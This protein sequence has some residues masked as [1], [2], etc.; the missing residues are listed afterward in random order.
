MTDTMPDTPIAE[1]I[2]ELLLNVGAVS[3]NVQEPFT[4]ASGIK[5]PIYCDNR[6]LISHPEERK[7]VIDAFVQLIEE[8]GIDADV[9]AGTATAGIPHA[10]WIADRLDKPMVYIRD[11]AK[12]HGKGNQIEGVVTEGASAVIIEDLI[13]T[14]GSCIKA[15]EAAREAGFVVTNVIAIF[16]YEFEA[17]AKTFD[18]IGVHVHTLS[19]FSTLM[20]VAHAKGALSEEDMQKALEW[21]QDPAGWGA[22]MGLE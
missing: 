6:L 1:K 16:S 14:G 10:A 9:I 3:L 20:K 19:N 7:L 13:S 5:S 21:N 2:A 17:A 4:Y 15:A 22:K 8:Q 11:K 12:E 18:D